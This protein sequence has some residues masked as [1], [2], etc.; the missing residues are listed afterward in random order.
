MDDVWNL[1]EA[2][3][4]CG[5]DPGEQDGQM[6]P[7]TEA[8]IKHFQESN[9]LTVDGVCGDQTYT[10]LAAEMGLIADRAGELQRYY[11]GDSTDEAADS[12]YSDHAETMSYADD[13]AEGMVDEVMA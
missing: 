3:K 2:L 4:M 1:Q 12:D 5:C 8:A 6:G 11:S 13:Q 9:E 7:K 10:S